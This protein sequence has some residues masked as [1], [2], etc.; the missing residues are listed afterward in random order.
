MGRRRAAV[1]SRDGAL[2]ALIT[3]VRARL[4]ECGLSY[5]KLAREIRYDRSWISRALSGQQLPPWPLIE[6]IAHGCGSDVETARELWAGANAA[7]RRQVARQTDGY[8]PAH[9][10]DYR[11]FCRALRN[12]LEQRGI[13]QRELVQRDQT[14]LLRRSTVGAI[15]RVQRSAPRDVTIA[16]VRASGV[17]DAAAA[18]WAAA[19]DRLGWPNRQ[20]MDKRRRQIA[21]ASLRARSYRWDRAW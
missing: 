11:Q 16:I 8:P 3:W 20:A 10:A 12:L 19:W 17:P 9:M 2:Q 7:R 6:H 14:G 4:D 13:S 18:D 5:A 1:A 15:L 21:Y